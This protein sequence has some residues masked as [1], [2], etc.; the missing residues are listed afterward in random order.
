MAMNPLFFLATAAFGWGLSLA[1]YR[2][3]ANRNGWP[4]GDP[5]ANHPLFV[6]L[7]GLITLIVAFLYATH[8]HNGPITT[9][10]IILGLG[11]LFALFWTGFLRVASQTALILGPLAAF[12]LVL[13]WASSDDFSADLKTMANDFKATSARVL[14]AEKRLQDRVQDAVEARRDRAVQPVAPGVAPKPY[15]PQ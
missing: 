5:Q 15:Q 1:T 10:W 9:G 14:E 2:M 12:L 13:G 6:M 7:V 11:L 8:G 4:L 3:V